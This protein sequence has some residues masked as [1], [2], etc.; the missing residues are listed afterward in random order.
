MDELAGASGKYM[1]AD[2]VPARHDLK[3]H[4]S[5]NQGFM[6]KRLTQLNVMPT[7]VS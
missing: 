5:K 7:E 2:K 3:A 1:E 4:A 6:S